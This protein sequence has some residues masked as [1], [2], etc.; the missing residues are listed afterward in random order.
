MGL[1]SGVSRA[2]LCGALLACAA[3]AMAQFSDSYNFL[4]AVRDANGDEAMKY[5][6]KPGAPVLNT[7]DP[8]TGETALHISVKAHQDN[9]VGFLLN[10]GADPE[11]KDRDGN[12]PLHDAALMGDQTAMTFLIGMNAKVNATNNNGETPLI[13]AVHR[14]DIALVRQLVDAGAD[15][16]IQDTIA[17]KSALDYAKQ[18]PRMGAIQKVLE[19]AKAPAKKKVAGPVLGSF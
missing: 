9:W 4:K 16:R 1:K 10:K 14:K 6:N 12:T 19:E 8:S 15:P 17:G 2:M 5:L 13:L 7:R 3:P 11:V 18:D